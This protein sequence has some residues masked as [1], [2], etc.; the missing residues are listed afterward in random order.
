MLTKTILTARG[1][2]C[3]LAPMVGALV[4]GAVVLERFSWE[5]PRVTTNER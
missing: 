3:K 1:A 5:I 4:N 2:G